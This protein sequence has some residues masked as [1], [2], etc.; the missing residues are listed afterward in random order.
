MTELENMLLYADEK[1]QN[2]E[3]Y[4]ENF[5]KTS[6]NIL[7]SDEAFDC[8]NLV[9]PILVDNQYDRYWTE[10]FGILFSLVRKSDTTEIP[11]QL[12]ENWGIVMKKSSFDKYNKMQFDELAKYYKIILNNEVEKHL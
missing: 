3:W 7:K 12:L 9:I 5:I 1:Y 10:I 4:F 2:D 8:I 6:I 11:T